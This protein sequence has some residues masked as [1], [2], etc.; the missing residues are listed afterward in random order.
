MV[1]YE[2]KGQLAKLLATEDL[3]IENRKVSTASFDVQNRVLTLPLWER[4]SNVVY[5]LL[6]GHEVGHALYTP[7]ED[8]TKK[9]PKVPKSFVNVIED[10]RIE[11]LMKQKF[12]GLAK[13]F[14]N[15][16]SDLS[17]QDFFGIE[18]EDVD[19]LS[20]MDRINL[21]YK[22]GN[23]IKISFTEDEK[24]Y[25]IKASKVKTFDEVLQ[26]SSDISDFLKRQEEKKETKNV[27]VPNIPQIDSPSNSTD[28]T[29]GPP[30]QDADGEKGDTNDPEVDEGEEDQP[31]QTT[32]EGGNTFDTITD[33]NLEESIEELSSHQRHHEDPAYV[34]IPKVNL[35]TAVVTNSAFYEKLDTFYS[36]TLHKFTCADLGNPFVDADARFDQ[37]KKSAQKEVNYLVKE[38]ECR[39]AA[40]SYA[41]ATTSRT[42][43]LDCSNLH[44]YKYNEDLFKKV[45]TLAEGKNHGLVFILD[46]SGSMSNVLLD[47]CKQLYNLIWFCK[48]VNIPFDVYAFTN[49]WYT[50]EDYTDEYG[51]YTSP[52]RHHDREE[53]E[54]EIEATFHLMNVLTSSVRPSEIDR[55][56]KTFW[57]LVS[58]IDPQGR[59]SAA[60][61]WPSSH[62]LSGT[63]LN[64][65]LITLSSLIPDFQKRHNVQKLQV[66]TLTDG[67]AQ[68]LK[69]NC[70][71]TPRYDGG[72]P[73]L[74]QR[75]CQ[76]HPTFIRDRKSGRT[77]SVGQEYHDLTTTLLR[78]LRDRFPESNFIGIRV[79][80]GRE[81]SNFSRRYLQWDYDKHAAIMEQWRKTKSMTLTNCGYNKYF[82]LNA[83]SLSQNADFEVKED[84]T[85]SQIKNAFKKSLNSKKMNKKVLGEFM[86][87]IA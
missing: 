8:W 26:L 57:R 20:F 15:G 51:R 53:N 70:T 38:F 5:D 69:Y 66:I 86:Q 58:S 77:Y 62:G 18:D 39:K 48:K 10:V 27:D 60:Y 25:V 12:P 43:I 14:Y 45:T 81:A 17:E 4:A 55:Q 63:P 59:W 31:M 61:Q 44:T 50:R 37:F 82:G 36:D 54:F 41:R 56:L 2:V 7:N 28:T 13:T 73:Y 35:D 6:V 47:T 32:N 71:F 83:S 84:A 76:Y 49:N 67:E 21:Y 68:G 85:K 33:K 24:P 75:T 19:L 11:R 74:G 78:Q 65:A 40:D 64:E 72:E 52:P 80:E 23:F 30:E 9:F 1:N 79:M 22:I 87:L 29:S 34:T 46:W 3:V 16:Y 42:G